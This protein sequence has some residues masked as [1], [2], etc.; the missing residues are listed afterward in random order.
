M[1][2][3]LR[4]VI[5][6]RSNSIL[7]WKKL[8]YFT[9]HLTIISKLFYYKDLFIWQCRHLYENEIGICSL[10]IG[11]T[12]LM[13]DCIY[14]VYWTH[15]WHILCHEIYFNLIDECLTYFPFTSM[16]NTLK[17]SYCFFV[18]V[19]C[20]FLKLSRFFLFKNV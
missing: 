3:K 11:I 16:Y 14:I 10:H 20:S 12:L 18:N 19:F 9:F 6:F 2:Q 8:T 5:L 1:C 7:K 15:F 13:L 4:K 17:H